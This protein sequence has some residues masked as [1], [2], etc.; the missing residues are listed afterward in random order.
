[1]PI[2]RRTA[3]LVAIG[4]YYDGKNT[5]IEKG[6][7][8]GR[9]TEEQKVKC[10]PGYPFRAIFWMPRFGKLYQDLTHEEH[11]QINHRKILYK[12]LSN[13]IMRL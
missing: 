3:H 2:E 10:E 8:D 6:S 1:V 12:K 13:K 5:I 9:I 4:A 11:E 7:T